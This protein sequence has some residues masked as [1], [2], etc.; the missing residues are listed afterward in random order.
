MAHCLR[1]RPTGATV[2]RAVHLR[3][4]AHSV[5]EDG[6]PVLPADAA[7]TT[8]QDRPVARPQTLPGRPRRPQLIRFVNRRTSASLN[9]KPEKKQT[10]VSFC[11]STF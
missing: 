6:L 5:H 1:L 8:P 4:L 11:S 9:K 3:L 2:G 10:V 7:A